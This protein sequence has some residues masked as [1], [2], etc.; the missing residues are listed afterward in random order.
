MTSDHTARVFDAV[1]VE[2]CFD[3][4]LNIYT[5]DRRFRDKTG[6]DCILAL[7]L[8]TSPSFEFDIANLGGG[9]RNPL[10]PEVSGLFV[11]AND[12]ATFVDGIIDGLTMYGWTPHVLLLTVV[13]AINFDF[14]AL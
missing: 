6:V 8:L 2:A 13:D 11:E 14:V 3:D 1:E 7:I 12:F 10:D 5:N 4:V 9:E